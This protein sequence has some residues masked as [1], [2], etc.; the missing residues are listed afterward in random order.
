MGVRKG[1][2]EEGGRQGGRVF[3][4]GWEGGKGLGCDCFLSVASAIRAPASLA[5]VF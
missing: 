5:V 4:G 1:G 2:G 3:R